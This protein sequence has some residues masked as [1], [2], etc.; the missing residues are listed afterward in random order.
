[1]WMGRRKFW[2]ENVCLIRSSALSFSAY[3][4]DCCAVELL[5]QLVSQR[6]MVTMNKQN[7]N[8]M[9]IACMRHKTRILIEWMLIMYGLIESD[10]G[11]TAAILSLQNIK[12]KYF[13]HR[14]IFASIMSANFISFIYNIFAQ[15]NVHAWTSHAICFFF[16]SYERN[17]C[18][19]VSESKTN[20]FRLAHAIF[21]IDF[22][23]FSGLY[24]CTT[25]F[26]LRRPGVC[27]NHNQQKKNPLNWRIY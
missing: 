3:V 19:L 7:A 21:T 24:T 4:V 2:N 27:H 14:S 26:L 23:R 5:Q 6:T 13:M 8:E 15:R 1:M 9:R 12:L 17:V 18:W 25:I 11:R 20:N 22:S 16:R 10:D